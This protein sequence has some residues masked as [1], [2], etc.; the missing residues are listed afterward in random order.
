MGE[1][2]SQE[3]VATLIDQ[4]KTEKTDETV[5]L[6]FCEL[7]LYEIHSDGNGG[8]QFI[9]DNAVLVQHALDLSSKNK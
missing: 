1:V 3:V 4:L 5:S 7:R 6:R 9:G 2:L 8:W